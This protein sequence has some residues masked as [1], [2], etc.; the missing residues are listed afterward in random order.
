MMDFVRNYDF[1]AGDLSEWAG[2]MLI[3][4]SEDDI[5]FN[6]FDGMKQ[7][8]PQAEYHKFEKDLGAHSLALITPAV[9]NQ[10]VA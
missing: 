3:T 8:Y 2:Q 5:V 10:R 9:F 6:Y 1:D 4:V 7:L